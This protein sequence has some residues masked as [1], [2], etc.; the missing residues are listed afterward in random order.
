L[1]VAVLC[2]TLAASLTVSLADRSD[3]EEDD[4][5]SDDSGTSMP[6]PA[7]VYVVH[8]IPGGDLGL[9]PALPVDVL[10]NDSLCVLAGF[11][12]GQIE[13]PL[14]L[15][16]G[17]YNLKIG[18]AD[19]T[20]PCANAASAPVIEADVPFAS[21]E[22]ASV[23]AYLTEGGAPTGG[24]FVNDLSRPGSWKARLIAQHTANAP[25]VDVKITRPRF[26]F[27]RPVAIPGLSNGDQVAAALLTGRVA[28]SISPAGSMTP[29]FGP[30]ELV[31]H[32][33]RAYL[34]YAVGGVQSG[35]FT[36]LVKEVMTTVRGAADDESDDESD[37]E[38]DGHRGWGGSRGGW[39]SQRR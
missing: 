22:S 12:F 33:H 27:A 18:L 19:T 1:Q 38:D 30:V 26:P 39:L 2:L 11:T 16:E 29:V 25:T 32:P 10:V 3:D 23:V 31:L 6:A 14:P 36:L 9:D 13:G 34:V 28:V 35:S 37:D 21:G 5:D 17:T 15:A 4:S 20:D 8:G 24:K 7:Q